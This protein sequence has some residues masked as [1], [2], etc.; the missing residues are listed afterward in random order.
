MN[1]DD[2]ERSVAKR[3]IPSES[4][5][6]SIEERASRL[7]C[8][9]RE[10]VSSHGIDVE[11]RFAGSYSKGTFLSD[12]DLDLFMMFPESLPRAELERIGL[13]AGEDILHGERMFSEHPYTRGVFE[14]IEVDM[15]PCYHLDSTEKL[16]SAVDRTPFHT[17]YIKGK[18]DAEGCNQV[19]LLKKFMKGI[20]T[21]GAEQDSRGFSGYLCELLVVH[22]GSFRKVLEGALTWRKGMTISINGCRGPKMSSP[23]VVYDPVDSRRNVSSAVHVDTMSTF[24]HAAKSYLDAP[25]ERFFFP[26]PRTPMSD[27]CLKS[28][29]ELH[30]AR[31]LSVSFNRPDVVEDSLHSQ[32]WKSQYA[33]SRKLDEFGFNTI[34]AVHRM[35]DDRMVCVFEIERDTLPT[36]HRHP[37]PPIWVNNSEAFLERWSDNEHGSPYIDD[38]VWTVVSP[39]QY[40]CATS[41]VSAELPMAGV[42]RDLDLATARVLGNDDALSGTDRTLLTELLDPKFPWE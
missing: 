13:K 9:V 10:Y 17:S 25:S 40:S 14:G 7:E 19:R 18:L 24:I 27:A 4:E 5:I 39:R 34:R 11:L 42:G 33:I 37:G 26:V 2:I 3:I 20:G 30:G 22:Y 8:M 29:L 28:R 31:L 21:Y 15:V 41:M 38:G 6:A 35:Y 1:H 12:P 32:L 36:V 16:Q 23:L